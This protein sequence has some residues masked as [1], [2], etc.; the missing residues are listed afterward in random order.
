[1]VGITAD[2]AQA[3]LNSWLQASTQLA[4]GK[5]YKLANGLEVTR[6]NAKY[7]QQQIVYW[8]RMLERLTP[9]SQGGRRMSSRYFPIDR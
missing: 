9:S 5:S 7:V 8:Q 4:S 3:Q 2:I 6:E 1:M